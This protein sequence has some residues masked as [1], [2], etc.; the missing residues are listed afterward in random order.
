MPSD[1]PQSFYKCLLKGRCVAPA[2]GDKEYTRLLDDTP[3]P[4][5]APVVPAVMDDDS[6]H[7]LEAI[8]DSDGH[9]DSRSCSE[10]SSDNFVE[11]AQAGADSG[12]ES[13]DSH[14]L[15]ASAPSLCLADIPSHVDGARI[16]FENYRGVY[17][18]YIITCTHHAN[19]SKS[20]NCGGA[21][22]RNFGE[23]EPLAY[24]AVWNAKGTD[25]SPETHVEGA[26]PTLQEIRAWL[27]EHGKL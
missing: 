10:H 19:C 15:E 13:S 22:V 26:R 8:C 12:T 18:R 24:L 17:E 6:D 25:F 20:R 27:D 9:A 21:Q 5:G 14:L 16:R 7:I 2:L 4:L 1:Q 23:W 11:P 3:L